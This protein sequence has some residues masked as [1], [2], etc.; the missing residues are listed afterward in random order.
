MLFACYR[1]SQFCLFGSSL[2]L[3]LPLW[4]GGAPEIAGL[5]DGSGISSCISDVIINDELL[6]LENYIAEENSGRGCSQVGVVMGW[7]VMLEY[8]YQRYSNVR[9]FRLLKYA[10]LHGVTFTDWKYWSP[11]SFMRT[12]SMY[13][14]KKVQLNEPL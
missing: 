12:G 5:S 14:Q 6:D 8:E 10:I 2:D 3:G 11:A 7:C 13:L 4:L 1:V 9:H